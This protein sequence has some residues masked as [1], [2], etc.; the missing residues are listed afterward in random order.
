MKKIIP[1]RLESTQ[2]YWS[3]CLLFLGSSLTAQTEF[4][5]MGA[6]AIPPP[7]ISIST[8]NSQAVEVGENTIGG[9]GML[10][11][12]V[13]S[14]RFLGQATLGA[15]IETINDV[16]AKGFPI[17]I[18]EQ[19]AM[20]YTYNITDFTLQV[21]VVTSEESPFLEHQ[22]RLKSWHWAWW[23]YV[24]T[25]PDI[26]RAKVAYALSQIFVISETDGTLDNY[27]LCFPNYY[28]MLSRNAFGNFRDLLEEVTYHPAMGVFLTHANNRKTDFSLNQF[29]DE[30]YAREVMQLFTIG[31]FELNPDGTEKLDNEGNLIPTYTLTDIT[32][33]AKVF[34]GMTFHDVAEYG[35][36]ATGEA[37]YTTPMIMDNNWHDTNTKNILGQQ[38]IPANANPDGEAEVDIA[39]DVLFQHPNVGPFISYRLIQRLVKSNPSPA[40][41][42]RV[43]A[44]FDDNGEGV[45]GD[46]G[47]VVKAILLDPE[48]RDCSLFDSATE[49]MLREPMVIYTQLMRA[50]NAASPNG[51]YRNDMNAFYGRSTQR[52]LAAPDVFNFYQV[53]YQP[54]GPIAEAGKVDPVFQLLNDNSLIGYANMV[55]EWFD[56][57]FDHHVQRDFMEWFAISANETYDEAQDRVDLD[58]S[59]ERALIEDQDLDQLIER[60]NLILMHGQM[61]ETTRQTIYNTLLQ[62]PIIEPEDSEM[63]LKL[64]FFLILM[65]PDYVILK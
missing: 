53:N 44:V 48:A 30:N 27:P 2:I 58:L 3:V 34:T 41:I 60:L 35:D 59:D 50:F 21:P 24:M 45:R 16:A 4:I 9:T 10:P 52:P 62:Y 1:K 37:S 26:L 51:E 42:A 33:L 47:A 46:L 61:T 57:S 22:L 13:A 32:E 49:G 25:S 36:G 15:D 39:L 40:Y 17:W 6:G 64:I 5:Q 31:L 11:N 12:Q 14:S 29:P 23:D 43:S 28:D 18:D 38:T 56:I 54:T 7:N 20:P 19:L 8:S 55:M 65:S 63:R